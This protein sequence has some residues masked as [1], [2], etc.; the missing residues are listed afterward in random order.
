MARL[1]IDP[2]AGSVLVIK[3]SALGDMVQAMAPM[4]AIRAYHKRARIT[5][6]TTPAYAPLLEMC[7]FVD[8][9][10][11][12]GRPRA[13]GDWL[14]L[15][16]RLRASR[17]EA[18]YDLQNNGRTA[19]LFRALWPSQ[20]PWSGVCLG[21]SH[22]FTDL[23]WRTMHTL[24]R[25]AAILRVAGIGPAEG[26]P[27]GGAPGPDLSFILDRHPQ[28][29]ALQP[30]HFGIRQPFALMVPGSSAHRTDKRWPVENFA[31]LA[32]RLADAGVTP[33]VTGSAAERQLAEAIVAA[34]PR[35]IDTTGRSDIFQVA[36]LAAHAHVAIGNDTG[37][38]HIAAAAGAGCVVLFSKA[39]NPAQCAPRGRGVVCVRSDDLKDVPVEDVERA[40]DTLW[41]LGPARVD[42]ADVLPALQRDRVGE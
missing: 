6:L 9:I 3:L 30:A 41:H 31:A 38:M 14:A 24:D 23:S 19:N 29:E 2:D 42:G 12:G 7:P 13:L 17:F 18:V 27:P 20:P 22:R 15:V 36:G 40:I 8:E 34:E 28:P 32:V 4:A 11:T 26:Y 35:T 10:D 16:G 21:A 39:S 33:V 37:P 5:V 1:P 25:H